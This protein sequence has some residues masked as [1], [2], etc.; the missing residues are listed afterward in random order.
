MEGNNFESITF[1]IKNHAQNM[2]WIKEAHGSFL[3]ESGNA[4]PTGCEENLADVRFLYRPTE[5][6]EKLE[7]FQCVLRIKELHTTESI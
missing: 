2:S 3:A 4:A 6:F 1:P 5:V 7:F